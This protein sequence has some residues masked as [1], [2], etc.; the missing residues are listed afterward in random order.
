[1]RRRFVMLDRDGTLL[2]ERHYLARVEDVQVLSGAAQA[3]ASFRDLGLG[4]ILLTNQSGVGRGLFDLKRL[5]DIHAKMNQLLAEEGARLDGIYFC[6]HRPEDGCKCRKP[7]TGMVEFASAELDFAPSEAFMIGDKS[8]DIEVGRGVGATT[9]LVQTGYGTRELH[10]GRVRPE[11]VAKDL[12]DAV[13]IIRGILSDD[14]SSR[15]T[16]V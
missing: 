8:S 12:L 15:R 1:M 13:N 7:A 10:E 11:Y 3:V 5:H 6:P 14:R 4:V 9:F 16:G 2:V